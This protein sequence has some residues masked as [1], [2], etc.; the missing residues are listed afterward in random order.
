M[1]KRLTIICVALI[2]VLVA[3]GI[4]DNGQ[5]SSL[6]SKDLRNLGDT[7]PPTTTSTIPPSTIE[8][9]T[10]TSIVDPSTTI[11]ADDVN[12]YFIISGGQLKGYPRS[13]AKPVTTNQVLSALQEGP[14]PG[15]LGVGIR[16]A[17][18]VPVS[19]LEIASE[20][21]FRQHFQGDCKLRFVQYLVIVPLKF[22]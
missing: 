20:D 8:P 11:A 15:D 18:P 21:I 2:A 16:S 22:I 12:L 1:L 17:V 19:V 9:T 4:P 6:Q 3:C 10:S 14:P 13:L 5:V 7:I